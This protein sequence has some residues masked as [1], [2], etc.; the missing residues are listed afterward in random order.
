MQGL[1]PS[2]LSDKACPYAF[3]RSKRGEEARLCELIA[4]LRS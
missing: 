2:E 3:V 1:L 4:Q